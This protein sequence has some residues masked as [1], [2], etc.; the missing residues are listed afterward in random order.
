[1]FTLNLSDPQQGPLRG[2]VVSLFV[3]GFCFFLSLL[4]R[5]EKLED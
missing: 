4:S 5:E 1:M 3:Y 2:R